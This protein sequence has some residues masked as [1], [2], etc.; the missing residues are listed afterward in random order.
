MAVNNSYSHKIMYVWQSCTQLP[1]LN[2]QISFAMAG[3]LPNFS[4]HQF[5]AI[6]YAG[7][8]KKT[9]EVDTL[10]TYAS[11]TPPTSW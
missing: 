4:S 3:N 11:S 6:Q 10:C 9:L 1:N 2:R 5:L 7:L 8:D